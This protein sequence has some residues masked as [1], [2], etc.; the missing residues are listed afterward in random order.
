MDMDQKSLRREAEGRQVP[1]MV[2]AVDVWEDREGIVMRADLPGVA[3][4]GL[5]IGI[6]GDNLTIEGAVSL[7]EPSKLQDVYAEVRVAQYRRTFVLGADLD[8]EKI[9][10]TLK[11][12]VLELRI[13]KLEAAK[14]RRVPVQAG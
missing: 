14:P 10:A 13:P 4:E 9:A 8:K 7:G 2:P 6:D 11:D 12:G 5:S 1:P 3:R